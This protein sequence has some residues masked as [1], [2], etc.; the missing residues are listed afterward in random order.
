MTK[1]ILVFLLF[2][3]S[4]S[5]LAAL[6]PAQVNQLVAEDSSDKDAAI[7]QLTQ[8]ADPDAVLVL[9]AMSDGTLYLAGDKAVIISCL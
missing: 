4:L 3:C 1:K 8:T 5:A 2:A 6:D 9:N 7:Q